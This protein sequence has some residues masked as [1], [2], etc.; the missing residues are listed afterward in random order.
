MNNVTTPDPI[1]NQERV[2]VRQ[3][4]T[5]FEQGIAGLAGLL[6]AGPLG[7]AA[8]WATI[9]GLQGKWAP[10][11]ILGFIGAP[12]CVFVQAVTIGMLTSATTPSIAPQPQAS[13]VKQSVVASSNLP[14]YNVSNSGGTTL[15]TKCQNMKAAQDRND[16][17]EV[18]TIAMSIGN[19]HDVPA[20]SGVNDDCAS[21]GVEHA[22]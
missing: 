8:S 20:F 1:T 2:M 10:W 4:A 18:F 19:D 9:R 12:V 17:G 16:W 7:A 5:G 21:V 11:A 6:T 15:V 13:E 22:A 3:T 14:A